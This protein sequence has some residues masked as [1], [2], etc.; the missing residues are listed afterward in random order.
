MSSKLRFSYKIATI[1]LCCGNLLAAIYLLQSFFRP[2]IPITSSSHFS[3]KLLGK[4]NR[5]Y[6]ISNQYTPEQLNHVMEFITIQKAA[7]P[8]EL[9]KRVKEMQE[10]SDIVDGIK[11][12]VSERTPEAVGLVGENDKMNDSKP[13]TDQEAL[14]EWR[15][16]KMDEAKARSKGSKARQDDY[17]V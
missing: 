13:K 10:E 15:R 5:S 8:T 14:D 9:I 4:S 7:E 11:D 2:V 16:K 17:Q 1:L 12:T 3:F 6:L